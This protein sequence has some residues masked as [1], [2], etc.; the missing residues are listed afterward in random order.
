MPMHSPDWKMGLST[1][2]G[3]IAGSSVQTIRDASPGS[4]SSFITIHLNRAI[5]MCMVAHMSYII[6]IHELHSIR[7]TRN[8]WMHRVMRDL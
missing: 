4:V 3:Q 2:A 5:P 1:S 7:E 6:P 8:V